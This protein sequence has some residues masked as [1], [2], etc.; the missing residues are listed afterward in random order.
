MT[1]GTESP[2]FPPGGLVVADLA[3][4][5]KDGRFT[6][7]VALNWNV[8]EDNLLYVFAARGYKPG[9]ANNATSEFGPETVWDYEFGWKG[10]SSTTM[11]APSSARSTWTTATFSS[12]RST[13]RP[14][15]AGVTNI[16]N[17]SIKGVEL[18]VQAKL[19]GLQFRRRTGLRGFDAGRR[20]AGGRAQP[21]TGARSPS[22]V[23]ARA[24]LR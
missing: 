20:H 24:R 16:S 17:A 4:S 7:K 10:A 3:G 12:M 21:A 22:A 13:S 6:G 15:R 2:I 8:D 9:G 14:A 1:I 5:H 18:Q 23:H 19:G 11:C